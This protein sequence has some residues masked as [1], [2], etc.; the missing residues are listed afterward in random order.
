MR[1]LEFRVGLLISVVLVVLF[2][3]F[4]LLGDNIGGLGYNQ[5]HHFFIKDASGLKENG[6]VKLA[7]IEVGVIDSIGLAGSIAKV[8]FKIKKTKLPLD[9]VIEI[10]DDSFFGDRYLS[11]ISGTSKDFLKNNDE[12]KNIHDGGTFDQAVDKIASISSTIELLPGLLGETGNQATPLISTIKNLENITLALNE[13][14]QNNKSDFSDTLGML[15]RLSGNVDGFLDNVDRS[16]DKILTSLDKMEV[17]FD[18]LKNLTDKI[19]SGEGTLGKLVHENE[20]LE[21][22]NST[23]S[24]VNDLVKSSKKLNTSLDLRGDYITSS[25]NAKTNISMIAAPNKT[26][27]IRFSIVDEPR[28]LDQNKLLVST[29]YSHNFDNLT[30]KGGIIENSG[31]FGVDYSFIPKRLKV[32]FES[33]RFTNRVPRLR[34]HVKFNVTRGVYLVGGVDKIL[35]NPSTY[36]GL[37]MSVT[38]NDLKTLFLIP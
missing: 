16:W 26:S 33:F 20:P 5:N 14:I 13:I 31:G 35:D 9:T 15:N 3:I 38:N 32:M 11:I 23:I 36:L 10:R 1:N 2:F 19:Q 12:I 30:V 34:S 17:A 28:I 25:A 24:G 8:E 27:N 6:R 37:G 22:L 7:G 4:Y 18:N 21:N 29:V